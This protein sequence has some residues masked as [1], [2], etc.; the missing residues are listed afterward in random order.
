MIFDHKNE[1]NNIP[2]EI[3]DQEGAVDNNYSN[4]GI[5]SN[6]DWFSREIEHT[7]NVTNEHDN[8]A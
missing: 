2:Q 5:I 1:I 7:E 4:Q 3:H 6:N 8:T